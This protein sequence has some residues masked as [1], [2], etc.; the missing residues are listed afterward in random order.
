MSVRETLKTLLQT[1]MKTTTL[2]RDQKIEA[3]IRLLDAQ[4][5]ISYARFGGAFNNDPKAEA[6]LKKVADEIKNLVEQLDNEVYG[7]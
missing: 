4:S 2:R 7:N 1:N 6:K 3:L 5:I